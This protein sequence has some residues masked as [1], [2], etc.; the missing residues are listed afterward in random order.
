MPTQGGQLDRTIIIQS[1]TM[2]QDAAGANVPTWSTLATVSAAV[3]PLSGS[4]VIA[5]QQIS[6]QQAQQFR[7]RYRADV[8]TANRLVYNSVTYGI[9]SV[10][11][12]GRRE[13]LVILA[14]AKVT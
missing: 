1:R 9:V 5:A 4:E 11:E 8:T 6:T 3:E 2:A 12:D 10:K 14:V 7:I 13:A